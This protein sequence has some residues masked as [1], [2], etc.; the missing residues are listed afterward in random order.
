MSINIAVLDAASPTGE[1]LIQL[2]AER[3][4]PVADLYALTSADQ[5]E[6]TIDFADELL[7]LQDV[8][9]F[10][11][12][13]VELVFLTGAAELAERWLISALDAG[14]KVVDDTAFSRQAAV[15]LLLPEWL[16]DGRLPAEVEQRIAVPG[17]VATALALA[18]RPLH[19]AYGL[20][21]LQG[22]SLQ[23]VS[24]A[25]TTGIEALSSEVRNLFNSQPLD[26]FALG[27]RI[28]FNLLPQIGALDADGWSN[29][30]CKIRDETRRLLQHAQLPVHF[31]A[32]R[33]PIFYS[34]ALI[35]TVDLQRAA[36]IE[37]VQQA[38]TAAGIQLIAAPDW[39]TP[40]SAIGSEQMQIGRLRLSADGK[41][42]SFW[43]VID[44][45]RRGAA[46]NSVLLAEA[47]LARRER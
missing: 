1:A 15:P 33:V 14:C 47:W 42:L 19:N 5:V 20:E 34:H 21:R 32:V 31:T 28:A 9:E 41:I 2:L 26:E 16:V 22:V 24:G 7:G 35:I 45:L 12:S 11:F 13:R 27:Q 44:N 30:E 25:G 38:L 46:W 17:A 29:E 3:G 39:P 10:D 6:R 40:Q 8:A 36:D 23:S 37:G 18:L 43:G 4:F